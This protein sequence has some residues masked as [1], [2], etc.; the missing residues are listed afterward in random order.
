MLG[1]TALTEERG[2][3][4]KRCKDRDHLLSVS[5]ASPQKAPDREEPDVFSGSR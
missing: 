3:K 5:A 1:I 2:A 4:G